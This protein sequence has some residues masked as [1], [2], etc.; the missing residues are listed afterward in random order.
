MAAMA[1]LLLAAAAPA[2]AG[3]VKFESIP[4]STV[5]R[6]ILTAKAAERLGIELGKVSEQRIVRKQMFGG[7]VIHPLRLQLVQKRATGAFAGFGQAAV[8][9]APKPI[10]VRPGE[11]WV[12]LT[13]TQEE[14]DRVAKDKPARILPLATRDKLAKEVYA[15]LSKISPIEDLKRTMLS[16]FYVVPEGDHGLKVNDRM[17]VELQLAGSNKKRK[18]TP[19]SSLYYDGKSKAWV[20]VQTKPLVYERKRVEVERIVGEHV[21]LKDGPPVGTDVVTVGAPLLYGAEVIYK[22]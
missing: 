12:R 9:P 10:A 5:K 21:V 4:G 18:V 15:T 7:Q 1:A 16:L 14:W 2:A 6:V 13:L 8:K 17:R 11:T 22:K 20:Y 3:A 19:Y